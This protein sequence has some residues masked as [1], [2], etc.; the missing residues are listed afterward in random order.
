MYCAVRIP[1]VV[2]FSVCLFVHP[3][4]LQLFHL[5]GN[6]GNAWK[7]GTANIGPR[8]LSEVVFEGKRG[9]SFNSDIAIDDITF[10]NCVP[11]SLSVLSVLLLLVVD[12][13]MVMLRVTK[14]FLLSALRPVRNCTSNF[15]CI[16]HF[17]VCVCV[18]LYVRVY[19]CVCVSVY[20]RVC[21]CVCVCVHVCVCVCPCISVC[22]H[23]C[24]CMFTVQALLRLVWSAS[25]LA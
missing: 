1:T 16:T 19:P 3:V 25:S 21:V 2:H 18:G 24:V 7:Q 13:C 20:I 11:G 10:V 12:V 14:D 8:Y 9:V 23:V 22:V 15:T 6:Q 5:V 17:H 4:S